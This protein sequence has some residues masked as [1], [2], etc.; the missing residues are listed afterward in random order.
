M[1]AQ[2]S[3]KQ[4]KRE[5]FLAKAEKLKIEIENDEFEREFNRY[6]FTGHVGKI[7]IHETGVTVI[8]EL[9]RYENYFGQYL[10]KFVTDQFEIKDFEGGIT[11]TSYLGKCDTFESPSFVDLI[12]KG[13]KFQEVPDLESWY[14]ISNKLKLQ[15]WRA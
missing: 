15:S 2:K 11:F 6:D 4:L 3:P 5:I 12:L 8:K 10:I 14:Y 9:I 13:Y 1:T 7:Y